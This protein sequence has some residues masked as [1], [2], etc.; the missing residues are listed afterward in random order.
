MDVVKVWFT[1]QV[2]WAMVEIPPAAFSAFVVGLWVLSPCTLL[3]SSRVESLEKWRIYGW[4]VCRQIT[5][6]QCHCCCSGGSCLLHTIIIS[7]LH[8][9]AACMIVAYKSW[10]KRGLMTLCLEGAFKQAGRNDATSG[11]LCLSL[12]TNRVIPLASSHPPPMK[13]LPSAAIMSQ[14]PSPIF[15]FQPYISLLSFSD[16][17]TS[18]NRKGFSILAPSMWKSCSGLSQRLVHIQGQMGINWPAAPYISF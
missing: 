17:F 1:R 16:L 2:F 13:M 14:S 5:L 6:N 4:S 10:I 7:L 18:C 8:L 3:S 11:G 15:P 12:Q 9:S